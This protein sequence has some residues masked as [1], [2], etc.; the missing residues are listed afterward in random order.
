MDASCGGEKKTSWPEVVGLP[1]KE[2]KEIIQ[3][4]RPD[5]HVVVVPVGSPVTMDLRTDRV[6]IFVDTVAQTPTVG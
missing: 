3:K 6:R 5:V 4:D 2:A 1:V